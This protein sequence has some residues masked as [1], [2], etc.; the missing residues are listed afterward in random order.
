MTEEADR[1]NAFFANEAFPYGAV[2]AET[3]VVP[4]ASSTE[5]AAVMQ[6]SATEAGATAASDERVARADLITN[7]LADN[8]WLKDT[9]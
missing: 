2:L 1:D 8:E 7:F 4:A 3:E 9:E 6:E 5:N